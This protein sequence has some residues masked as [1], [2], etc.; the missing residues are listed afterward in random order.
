VPR[1]ASRPD[2]LQAFDEGVQLTITI[3]GNEDGLTTH[4]HCEIIIFI[5]DLGF[6]CEIDPVSLPD[7]SHLKSKRAGSVKMSLATRK[8]PFSASSSIKEEVSLQFRADSQRSRA[9]WRPPGTLTMGDGPL[10]AERCSVG[11]ET[12]SQNRW[13]VPARGGFLIGRPYLSSLPFVYLVA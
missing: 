10:N 8:F 9:C 7:V 2:G 4:V 12:F 3:T 11:L 13:R 1:R 6:M 5:W